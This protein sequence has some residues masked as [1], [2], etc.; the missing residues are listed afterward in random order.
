M[1]NIITSSRDFLVYDF[2]IYWSE[3]CHLQIQQNLRR[4]NFR[5]KLPHEE[6]LPSAALTI[7]MVVTIYDNWILD[8]ILHTSQR[9]ICVNNNLV[10]AIIKGR[11]HSHAQIRVFTIFGYNK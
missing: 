3:I 2:I 6:L 11:N 10:N 5:T 7:S 4:Q 1:R 8:V 9:L